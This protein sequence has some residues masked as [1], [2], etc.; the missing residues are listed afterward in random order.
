LVNP[1]PRA[2]SLAANGIEHSA[3]S[4]IAASRRNNEDPSE[5]T[6]GSHAGIGTS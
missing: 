2:F 6:V 3:L 4:L 1:H 5:L